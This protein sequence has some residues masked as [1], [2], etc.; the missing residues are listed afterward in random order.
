MSEPL[1]PPL[2]PL[3]IS[4][5]FGNYIQPTGATPTLGTFTVDARPGRLWRVLKTVRYYRRLNAWV[6]RIGL[7]NPGIDWLTQQVRQQRIDLADKIVSIHGFDASQWETL[8]ETI[9]QLDPL[10][11]EL[12]MSCP[13]VGEAAWPHD[14]FHKAAALGVP[15]IVK[16]PPIHYELMVDQARA[17]GLRTFHCCNT[18][19]IPAGGL[20]GA[21]LK[22]LSLRCIRYLRATQLGERLV[23]I[24]GGGIQTMADIDDYAEAG[25]DHVALGTKT[26]NP[27]LL[28]SHASLHPL[29]D[30][31]Q[32]R[33]GQ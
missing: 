12:N 19:P 23:L 15:A 1:P 14:L 10:A 3:L 27:W 5:P 33:M 11:V 18:L 20:S 2:K 24:G 31:A 16:L 13:N 32:Q 29:I 7:R 9:D 22:P 25:A 30:Y 4:A 26:M 28:V 17:A 6:N 21:P 8:L